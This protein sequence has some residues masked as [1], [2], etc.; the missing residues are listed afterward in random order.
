MIYIF[1]DVLKI[2]CYMFFIIVI[3]M[4]CLIVFFDLG[5]EGVKSIE[6]YKLFRVGG[7]RFG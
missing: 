3:L 1:F 2:F 6:G 5:G 7:S 4:G